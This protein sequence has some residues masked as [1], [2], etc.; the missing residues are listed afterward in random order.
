M[1]TK[2]ILLA[3]AILAIAVVS[4]KKHS[5]DEDHDHGN[6]SLVIEFDHVWGTTLEQFQLNKWFVHPMSKDSMKFTMLRYYVSNIKL[7][8]TDGN[9]YEIPE[10]YY[11]VDASINKGN[12]L[13]INDIPDGDYTN[14]KFTM[15]V[16]SIRNVSGVQTGALAPSNGMFWDW[17]TGYIMIKAEGESPQSADGTFAFHLGGFSGEFNVVR[18]LSM[19]FKGAILSIKKDASPVIHLLVNPARFRHTLGSLSNGSTKVH[20]PGASAKTMADDFNTWIRFD[21]IHN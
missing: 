11:L 13:Q 16:D 8:K 7:K 5:H 15:G 21:H 12:E 14:I 4:C 3:I 19:D 17:N 18:E 9:W 6:S 1:K 2:K 20:M 10:S